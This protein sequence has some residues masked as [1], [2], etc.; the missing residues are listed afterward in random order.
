[1]GSVLIRGVHNVPTFLHVM[2]QTKGV[3]PWAELQILNC[4][5]VV[6]ENKARVDQQQ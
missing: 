2:E 1:M 4:V 6:C 5:W 3:N